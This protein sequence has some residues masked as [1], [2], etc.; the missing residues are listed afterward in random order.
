MISEAEIEQTMNVKL[1]NKALSDVGDYSMKNKNT[2]ER[3]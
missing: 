2:S 1:E 3:N